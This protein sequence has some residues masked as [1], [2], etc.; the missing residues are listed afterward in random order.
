MVHVTSFKLIVNLMLGFEPSIVHINPRKIKLDLR[1]HAIKLSK[2]NIGLVRLD[3]R[4]PSTGIGMLFYRL[5]Q[6]IA[7]VNLTGSWEPTS[8]KL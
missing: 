1:T 8:T 4:R 2:F 6:Y 3:W 5:L 7:T